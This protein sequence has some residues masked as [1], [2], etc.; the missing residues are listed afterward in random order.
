MCLAILPAWLIVT[1]G[2]RMI[3]NDANEPANA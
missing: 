3:V 1:R 2:P